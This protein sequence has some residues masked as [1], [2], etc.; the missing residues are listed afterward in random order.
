[1]R[2]PR[3]VL[4]D[5]PHHVILR[6]NNRRRIFSYPD[7][8]WAFM[9]YLAQ[10]MAK[11]PCQMHALTLMTN[12]VHILLTPSTPEA[13]SKL[14]HHTAM[15]YAKLRNAG[16]SSTGKLFEGPFKSFPVLGDGQLA[17]VTAYIELN[18]VRAGMRDDPRDYRY[19]TYGLHV[20]GR[21][22]VPPSLWTP[23]PW[24]R[25]LGDTIQERARRYRD[26]VRDCRL[27]DFKPDHFSRL[28][29][30]EIIATGRDH[31]LRRP[32]EKRAT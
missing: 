14:V 20:D 31:R 19:S 22:D 13:M 10:G 6:G 15:R 9:R 12:H 5:H 4:L 28:Q 24:Y 21:C 17:R 25:S 30:L 18:P 8:Y 16:R 29:A 32:D 3:I 2:Y 11:H 1:M 23:S 26:W 7:D 27:Q